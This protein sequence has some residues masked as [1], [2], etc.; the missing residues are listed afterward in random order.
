[1][2]LRNIDFT[3]P[4]L[5]DPDLLGCV[6]EALAALLR[7]TNGF[8]QFQGG[9]HVRG[10]CKGPAW[11][12]LRHAWFGADAFCKLY[13][14]VRDTDVPFAEDAVGDQFLLR[15][16]VVH[17]LAAETGEIGS[18]EV[19]FERFFADAQANPVDVLQLQ[20]LLQYLDQAPPPRPG[21]LLDVSPP[22]CTKEA[23]EGVSLRP[24]STLERRRALASF[25]RRTADTPAGA[26]VALEA[27]DR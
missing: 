15:D 9:L 8:V 6:P 7:D 24:I 20:P 17:C 11:H 18:L 4:A 21:Q 16:G 13:D 10:A 27:R 5:D 19:T 25:A 2:N 14:S 1:M 12:S 26:K 3:G 22:F 23:E